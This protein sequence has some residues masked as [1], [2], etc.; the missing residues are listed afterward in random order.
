MQEIRSFVTSAG[1]GK[2]TL[3]T[4]TFWRP[5]DRNLNKSS[6]KG[7]DED[8]WGVTPNAGYELKLGTKEQ[9]D[10]YEHLRDQE[11]ILPPGYVP[12][13]STT[14]FRDRQLELALEYLRGQIR[15]A[16]Q[17]SKKTGG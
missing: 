8:E 2:L 14:D 5:S 15:T 13:A 4:A 12:S 7:R 1:P 11:I 16:S 10:L 17:G 6:T 9:N 3:T